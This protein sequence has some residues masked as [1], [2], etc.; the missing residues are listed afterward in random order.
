MAF[1]LQNIPGATGKLKPTSG[2]DKY[3]QMEISIGGKKFSSGKKYNIYNELSILLNAGI[4]IKDALQLIIENQKNKKDKEVLESILSNVIQGKTLSDSLRLTAYFSDYEF[5]S[6]KIGEETG[7][8]AKICDGLAVFFERKNEQR[9]IVVSA[10][11]Y[12]AIVLTTAVTVVIFM[13]SYV[14]PMFEDIFKQNNIELPYLT[15]VIIGFSDI[16][17]SYGWAFVLICV[18]AVASFKYFSNNYAFKS[19]IHRFVLAFP[20]IGGFIKRIYLAQFMQAISLLTNAKFPLLNSIQI[21]KHMISFTPL[22]ESLQNVETRIL[23]GASLSDSLKGTR[24]FDDRIVALIKVAEQTN[25]M[26]FVFSQLNEQ[27]NKEVIRQSKLVAT[28]LEPFIIIVVGAIVGIL[29]IALYLPMF[30][31]STVIG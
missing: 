14:V 26:E 13:L 17:K 27:Y 24:M 15:R 4:T 10:L 25:Q 7:A 1:K 19:T 31:L 28:V 8:L 30:K 6:I 22:Q 23:V 2:I 12:P 5:Y 29:L 9:K 18:G 21:I 3:L 20:V 11:T 16:V